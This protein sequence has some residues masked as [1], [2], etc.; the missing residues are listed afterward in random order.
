M[1]LDH[2]EKIFNKGGVANKVELSQN[3]IIKELGANVSALEEKLKNNI[4][5]IEKLNSERLI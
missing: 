5:E 3:K 1:M 4:A 2:Q